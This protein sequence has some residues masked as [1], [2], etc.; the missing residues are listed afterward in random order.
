MEWDEASCGQLVW[1]YNEA[2]SHYAGRTESFLMHSPDRIAS[3][4]PASSRR[5]L[6]VASI[7]IGGGTTDMA[8]VHY[9]LDDGV[10]PM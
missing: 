9:Q 3:L 4:N 6:R 8:I 10:G 7:D 2:I 1:L 5:A